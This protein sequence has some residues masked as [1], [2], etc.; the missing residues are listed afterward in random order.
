ML[1]H[2]GVVGNAIQ[3]ETVAQ[4][5]DVGLMVLLRL[6]QECAALL[7]EKLQFAQRNRVG[8]PDQVVVRDP[9][10]VAASIFR[11]CCR[12]QPAM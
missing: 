12:N 11:N 5:A 10:Q 8:V 4:G 6:L 7:V 3:A 9:G 1:G 2:E